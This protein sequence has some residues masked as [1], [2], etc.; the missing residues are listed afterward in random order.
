MQSV[1]NLNLLY[2]RSTLSTPHT[3]LR[4]AQIICATR[5]KSS[6]NSKE[7]VDIKSYYYPNTEV[8]IKERS[9]KPDGKPVDPLQTP[10]PPFPKSKNPKTGEVGG[11]TGPEPTRFGDW[12]RKGRVTDF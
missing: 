2:L 5:A 4:P 12:E 3:I 1:R 11:P 8:G 10:F 6:Q 9:V 7:D